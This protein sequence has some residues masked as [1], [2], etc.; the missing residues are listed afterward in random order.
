MLRAEVWL[1]TT[2]ISVG[3]IG[4]LI[5]NWPRQPA[6]V[7]E[8]DTRTAS[9]D[10]D[11]LKEQLP[12]IVTR[13]FNNGVID[14]EA[15]NEESDEGNGLNAPAT[16][17]ERG[18]S[19]LLVGN[20]P[21][22]YRSYVKASNQTRTQSSRLLIKLALSAEQA[23][24]YDQG[25]KFYRK[26][27]QLADQEETD[28]LLALSGISRIW[29]EQR[30]FDQSLELL[31]ELFLRHG[32][33][34]G[35]PEEVRLQIAYQLSTA[36]QLP[37]VEA[38]STKFGD[39]NRT[40]FFWC[41][42]SAESIIALEEEPRTELVSAPMTP[43]EIEIVV[44]QRPSSDIQ[45][46][47][48]DIKTPIS[49]LK[50]LLD[51]LASACQ[52]KIELSDKASRA[53]IGRSTKAKVAGLPV[54]LILD[55][56]VAPM[57]M[58]WEQEGE[59]LRIRHMDELTA[60]EA[61][62][63]RFTQ[64]ERIMRYIEISYQNGQRRET[65]LLHRGNLSMLRGDYEKAGSRYQE[66]AQL[67]TNGEIAAKLQFNLAK[68]DLAVGRIDKAIDRLFYVVDQTL[69]HRLQGL[70]YS[71]I[72][73]VE[74]ERGRP[75]QAIYATSRGFSLAADP[76][77]QEDTLMTLVKSYLLVNDPFSANKL[78]FE[79]EKLIEDERSKRLA[80]ALA[81]YSR[82]L[83]TTPSIGLR[84]E[85]E[86]L[87]IA[88][89]AIN[90][91]ELTGFVDRLLIG[92]ALFEVGFTHRSMELLNDALAEA[93]EGSWKRRVAYEIGLHRFRSGEIELADEIL[94]EIAEDLIDP[95]GIMAQLLLAEISL[96]RKQPERC[97]KLSNQIWKLPLSDSQKSKTL[98][99]MGLAY[100]KLGQ[101]YSAAVCFS[102]MVPQAAAEPNGITTPLVNP[103]NGSTGT[104]LN[105][106]NTALRG[107]Q[108]E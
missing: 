30:Q 94:S 86:R 15:G 33:D 6:P 104:G 40:E 21:S 13:D 3:I 28:K 90:P 60:K 49:P 99:M 1:T 4:G 11:A 8:T 22:A 26:A 71:W 37:L 56:L 69:D 45:L 101:H 72:G 50:R 100:Q 42:P 10:V 92:R 55:N 32:S 51:E 88:L 97:L 80:S 96:R 105:S 12:N 53:I 103:S 61:A 29:Q 23:G 20:Y 91:S 77:V 102:G 19:F 46:I 87:V 54:S 108:N 78:L 39:V 66:L 16:E 62:D 76:V 65:S 36:I 79:N 7:P 2:L 17:V 27:I 35:L 85:G 57:D 24:Y 34:E 25:E 31:C 89:A 41:R 52:L 63:F 82:Y 18:D 83:G 14:S 43:E 95:V 98:K 75:Q 74:L 38:F 58:T 106:V 68:L 67:R 107:G 59:T 84:N 9:E 73:R 44:L 81:A 48:A 93:Q 5:Y 70:G 64:A 47:A